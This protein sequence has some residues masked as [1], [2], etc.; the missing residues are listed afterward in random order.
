VAFKAQ[1]QQKKP[2][3]IS[4]RD[5]NYDR[6]GVLYYMCIKMIDVLIKYSSSSSSSFFF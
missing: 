6:T 3:E 5:K 2:S 4:D 1:T